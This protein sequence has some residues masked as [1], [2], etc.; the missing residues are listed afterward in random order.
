VVL[1]GAHRSRT[2]RTAAPGLR[3]RVL[4]DMAA[5][6][7]E[8]SN[9][10]AL[11][12]AA[13]RP[14]C[15]PGWA[16]PW[17]RHVR[18]S[19]SRLSAVAV[20]Q[21]AELVGLAPL[22]LGRTTSGLTTCR[23]LADGAGSYCE[24][25]AA[26]HLRLDVAGALATALDDHA[27]DVLSLSAVPVD[28]PWPQLLQ[29]VW[30]GC[31]PHLSRV[32]A[33]G[34]PYV[35][36]R[37]GGTEEWFDGRS[38]N[39]RQQIRRRRREFLRRGGSLQVARTEDD[40]LTGLQELVRLHQGRWATRGGSQALHGSMPE[41]LDSAC[42]ELGPA[43]LQ[44]W[45]ATAEGV[46]VA[47]VLFM[48][49]GEEMHYWLGGFD[50]AWAPLSPSLL[51]LVE[52]VMHGPEFGC[53]RISL[54]PGSQP[55]KQRMATGE[56]DLVWVDVLPRT[57]RYPYVRLRQA[58]YRF[59]RIVANR[60]PPEAKNRLRHAVDRL[61]PTHGGHPLPGGAGTPGRSPAPNESPLD[62]AREGNG[63]GFRVD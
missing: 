47:A 23:V 35:D 45:T 4:T 30:P 51:L 20:H 31:R 36:L 63:D 62:G 16:L 17:W 42:R 6:E 55:Y 59:R 46:T 58:P 9:W 24:P 10:D 50:Q 15:A 61:R 12:G 21:G 22:Y 27:V 48:A 13:S 2:A 3:T 38:R 44:V 37:S 7:H 28:S 32:S 60:T 52:A 5:L 56:D 11:A 40:A 41:M 19:G 57:G 53:R 49:A 14:Y 39:F 26:A 54:G 33:M 25:L 29:E 43:R 18:P 34:S 1:H 8:R